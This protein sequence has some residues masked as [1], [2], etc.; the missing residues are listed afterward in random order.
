MRTVS[1]NK[2][3]PETRWVAALVIP[4]LVVAFV[5][6]FFFPGQTES[7][8]AW[9]IQPSMSAM[10]LAAAYAGGIVFLYRGVEIKEM[11]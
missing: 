6:L 1:E 7:L 5:I 9:K 11:A 4:F 2:I 3:L 10:M 8:F